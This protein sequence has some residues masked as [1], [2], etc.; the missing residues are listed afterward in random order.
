M[1]ECVAMCVPARSC[2]YVSM[3]VYVCA[4]VNMRENH[5]S[6]NHLS[7]YVLSLSGL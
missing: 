5:S 6:A 3:C 4:S 1:W 7:F 2:V